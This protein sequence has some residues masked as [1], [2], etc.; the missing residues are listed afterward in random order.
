M[1][2]KNFSQ[3]VL[4]V[5]K[6]FWK[7]RSGYGAILLVLFALGLI[8]L[9]VVDI[10]S[11]GEQHGKVFFICLKAV[12]LGGITGGLLTLNTWISEMKYEW[13]RILGAAAYNIDMH[14]R[15]WSVRFLY[16]GIISARR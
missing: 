1:E 11:R 6:Y 16:I 2:T 10:T 4:N 13:Q 12:C 3:R 14:F 5:V 9:L 7:Q 8:C 15:T